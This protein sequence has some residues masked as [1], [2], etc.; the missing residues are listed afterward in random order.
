MLRLSVIAAAGVLL[1]QPVQA[2]VAVLSDK[3]IVLRYVA[4]VPSPPEKTW[5]VLV[6]PLR[7]GTA[8][9]VIPVT[10]QI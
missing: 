5:D 8:H 1:W 6:A 7:G 10:P 4:A 3:G 2:R 9:T